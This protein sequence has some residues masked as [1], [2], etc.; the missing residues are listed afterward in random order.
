VAA[1][2]VVIHPL[3]AFAGLAEHPRLRLGLLA[4]VASGVLSLGLGVASNAVDSGPPQGVTVSLLLPGLFVSFWLLQGWLVDAGAG[5]LGRRGRTSSF[6]AVS[7]YAFI[8][9]IAYGALALFEA[10]ALRSAGA[11]SALVEALA[12]CTLPILAWFL[13]LNVLA[14]RAVYDVPTLN[15]LAFSLLPYALLSAAILLVF[16]LFAVRGG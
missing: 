14:I 8:P 13:F 12:W 4:V 10:A 5:M 1:F 7:G 3:E 2:A 16:L 11:G 6:L 9:W 15:A